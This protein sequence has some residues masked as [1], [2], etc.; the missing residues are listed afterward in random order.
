[1]HSQEIRQKIEKAE[2]K[3]KL[4][5]ANYY[6]FSQRVE[7]D[8]I[9]EGR[10]LERYRVKGRRYYSKIMKNKFPEAEA[11]LRRIRELGRAN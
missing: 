5:Q 2:R 8:P 6:G 4:A 11:V 7:N 10:F 3:L 9:L 1:M